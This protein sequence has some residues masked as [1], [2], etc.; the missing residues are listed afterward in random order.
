MRRNNQ[1]EIANVKNKVMAR[2]VFRNI[3]R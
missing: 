2:A 1:I 3:V